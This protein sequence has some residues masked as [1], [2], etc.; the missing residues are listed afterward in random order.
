MKKNGKPRAERADCL[1]KL[2]DLLP[3]DI[4]GKQLYPTLTDLLTPRF[5]DGVLTRLGSKLSIRVDGSCYVVV[6]D[7]PTEGV[8]AVVS[9]ETLHTMLEEIE[10]Y[11]SSGRAVWSM[12]Y[13]SRKKA[14]R[15]L[16]V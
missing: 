9:L 16:D 12:N 14:R 4:E 1:S 7:C 8:Q 10:R 11:V 2:G 13:E 5:K 6:V 15:G 3:C